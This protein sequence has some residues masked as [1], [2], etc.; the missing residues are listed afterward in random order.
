MATTCCTW[1]VQ[2]PLLKHSIR[3][4]L[5]DNLPDPEVVKTKEKSPGSPIRGRPTGEAFSP[6][7]P[8]GSPLIDYHRQSSVD[9]GESEDEKGSSGTLSRVSD[10]ERTATTSITR[11]RDPSQESPETSLDLSLTGSKLPITEYP[12]AFHH[13]VFLRD[14]PGW[15]QHFGPAPLAAGGWSPLLFPGHSGLSSAYHSLALTGR[16]VSPDGEMLL[17]PGALVAD[18]RVEHSAAKEVRIS[19]QTKKSPHRSE[20]V[21]SPPPQSPKAP[22]PSGRPHSKRKHT[23]AHSTPAS[24]RSQP[25]TSP[26]SHRAAKIESHEKGKRFTHVHREQRPHGHKRDNQGNKLGELSELETLNKELPWKRDDLK[27]ED[28]DTAEDD[29]FNDCF[30]SE[31]GGN[32]EATAK[33]RDI[34]EAFRHNS[35]VSDESLSDEKSAAK[36]QRRIRTTFTPEQLRELE[37]VFQMTHYPDVQTRDILAAKTCL[38]EQRI[39]IWFQNRR[40]KWRKYE[41]LGNFGGLQDLR[42]TH[43]VPAP[44]SLPRIDFTRRDPSVHAFSECSLAGEFPNM[45][46]LT[47]PFPLLQSA[48]GIAIPTPPILPSLSPMGPM[49]SLERAPLALPKIFGE[50]RKCSSIAS[51]RLKAR[52][53]EASAGIESIA[54]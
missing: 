15:Y 4:I 13:P 24:P 37:C 40:A 14:F 43:I 7:S 44:K 2:S 50:E 53:H 39:Q 33:K 35:P 1:C 51:L 22:G 47:S 16:W 27:K 20:S 3:S 49:S 6:A 12:G 25:L 19:D 36:R 52:Q 54:S 18:G 34:S 21:T 11:D 29:A 32:L 30:V 45:D 28:I 17:H 48:A 46:G 26:S 8:D 10:V 31:R 41:R 9:R 23:R 38:G 5:A 42:M